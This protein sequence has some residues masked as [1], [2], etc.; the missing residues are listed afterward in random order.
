MRPKAPFKY[1]GGYP[2]AL[3]EQVHRLI[4]QDQ[5]AGLLLQKYP[6]AHAVR[7][8][9]ALYDYV[10][11]LKNAYLRNAGPVNKVMFDGKLQVIRHALGTH[12]SLSR[13]QGAKLRSKCEIRV[14]SIFK[15][16][17]AAFLRMIVV[18]ELAHIKERE[19]DKAFYQLCRHMEPDYSQL[20][21]DLRAYL[22]YLEATGRPLWSGV[23]DAITPR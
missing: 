4:D 1:L 14:A 6:V 10:S 18:H 23:A 5:L 17:P 2:P 11:D 19:H 3:V 16:M 21:F 22:T 8:D 7:T 12:T 15:D 13:V 9:R 20:E